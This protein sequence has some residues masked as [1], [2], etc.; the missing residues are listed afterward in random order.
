MQKESITAAIP[1]G[2][3]FHSADFSIG[4]QKGCVMLRRNAEDRAKW[5]KLPD[6]MWETVPLYYHGFG[7]T[8]EEAIQ[9]AISAINNDPLAFCFRD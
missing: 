1:H 2:F 3:V 9:D 6:G 7:W 5:M 8:L 4:V